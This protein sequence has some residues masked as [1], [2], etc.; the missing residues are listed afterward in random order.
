MIP[1]LRLVTRL[2]VGTADGIEEAARDLRQRRDAATPLVVGLQA[3]VVT[4]RLAAVPLAV[5]TL[6]AETLPAI[7]RGDR[8]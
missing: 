6:L 2:L 1:S 3:W 4:L 7:V 8:S 5:G